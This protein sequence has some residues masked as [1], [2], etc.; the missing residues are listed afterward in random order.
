VVADDGPWRVPI[1]IGDDDGPALL[2]VH[3][4]DHVLV[5]GPGRSGRT[6]ALATIGSV[7]LRACPA[8]AVVA[9]PGRRSSLG[10]VPGLVVAGGVEAAAPLLRDAVAA[11]RPA[12]LLVDDAD[13]VDDVDGALERLLADDGVHVV[14][15]GRADVLRGLYGHWTRTV[16]RS[17][18]GVLLRPD[19]DLD[20][21]L[22]GAALP[23]R[24][25]APWVDGRGYLVVDGA[26]ALVQVARCKD[27]GP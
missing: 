27:A 1:G 17:R 25:S 19:P 7:V 18:L 10:R 11:G 15:A 2:T 3:E 20:G 4:G 23:R 21:E 13:A 12:V 16:R 6:T 9:L 14:A 24:S 22:L 5:A 8:A 26:P